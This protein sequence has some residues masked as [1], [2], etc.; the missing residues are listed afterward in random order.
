MISGSIPYTY[1]LGMEQ[2]D[3]KTCSVCTTSIP[4]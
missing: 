2:L 3:D 1:A 4:N